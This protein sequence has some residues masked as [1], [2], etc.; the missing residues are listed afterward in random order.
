MGIIDR[1]VG[2]SAGALA[3][4]GLGIA[5]VACGAGACWCAL[6]KLR[7]RDGCASSPRRW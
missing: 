7:G 6:G 1:F 3:L 5:L 4:L 2:D